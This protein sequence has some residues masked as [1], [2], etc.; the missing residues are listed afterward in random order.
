M[1]VERLSGAPVY[2][3]DAAGVRYRVLDAIVRDGDMIQ[4]NPP[5]AWATF[6]VF[7]P[8]TGQQRVYWLKPGESRAPE[9]PILERQ[10][11]DADF[12]RTASQRADEVEP[13]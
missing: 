9:P 5:T 3:T 13:P 7:R 6:R 4:A 8:E 1:P 12:L 11:R 10:L 2:F